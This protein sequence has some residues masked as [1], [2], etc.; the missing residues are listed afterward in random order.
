[1]HPTCRNPSRPA[2][3]LSQIRALRPL[4]RRPK[5]ERGRRKEKGGGR[6]KEGGGRRR[7]EKG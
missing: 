3:P 6:R 4:S 2:I 5:E 1:M 7:K